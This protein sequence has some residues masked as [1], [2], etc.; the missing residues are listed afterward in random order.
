MKGG[1]MVIAIFFTLSILSF[2]IGLNVGKGIG[3]ELP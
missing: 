1:N 3:E 2:L